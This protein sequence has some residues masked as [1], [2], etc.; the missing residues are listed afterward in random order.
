MPQVVIYRAAAANV[1]D[2]DDFFQPGK[3]REELREQIGKLREQ[4]RVILLCLSP[5]KDGRVE[6]LCLHKILEDVA[7]VGQLRQAPGRMSRSCRAR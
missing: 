2:A 7:A 5:L 6:D 1:Q 4:L 3:L